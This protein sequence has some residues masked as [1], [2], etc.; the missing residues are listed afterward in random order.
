MLT[1]IENC[2]NCPKYRKSTTSWARGEK[3]ARIAKHKEEICGQDPG[4]EKYPG[5]SEWRTDY[6]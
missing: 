5:A 6:S 3:G 4:T 1:N 2:E